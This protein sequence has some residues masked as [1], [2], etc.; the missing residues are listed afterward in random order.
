[1]TSEDR[2][3]YKLGFLGRTYQVD[4]LRHR[5][6]SAKAYSEWAVLRDQLND[7][8]HE[9]C[10]PLYF[11]EASCQSGVYVRKEIRNDG[12]DQVS[13][14]P[15]YAR[16]VQLR[17]RLEHDFRKE[18]ECPVSTRSLT[19]DAFHIY[20]QLAQ[21]ETIAAKG[22]AFAF[23]LT[24][25]FAKRLAILKDIRRAGFRVHYTIGCKVARFSDPS[26]PPYD[27]EVKGRL[28]VLSHEKKTKERKPK[29]LGD[30]TD[31][32]DDVPVAKPGKRGPCRRYLGTPKGDQT[33]K[34]PRVI[35][36]LHGLAVVTDPEMSDPL[37]K[38]QS[39]LGTSFVKRVTASNPL[40]MTTGHKGKT[41]AVAEGLLAYAVYMA[42]NYDQPCPIR[43]LKRSSIGGGAQRLTKLEKKNLHPRATRGELEA[44]QKAKEIVRVKLKRP[45]TGKQTWIYRHRRKIW[46]IAGLPVYDYPAKVI[47]RNGYSHNIRPQWGETIIHQDLIHSG[48][49]KSK[50]GL[51]E[52]RGMVTYIPCEYSRPLV[53]QEHAADRFRQHIGQNIRHPDG[54]LTD[55]ARSLIKSRIR[56]FDGHLTTAS[57][58]LIEE[59]VLMSDGTLSD[60]A[61]NHVIEGWRKPTGRLT[62]K[63]KRKGLSHRCWTADEIEEIKGKTL[64]ETHSG[65]CELELILHICR[66]RRVIEVSESPDCPI[67]K[68]HSYSGQLRPHADTILP[69]DPLSPTPG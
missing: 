37:G 35:P 17:Y 68:Y 8:F 66:F 23:T 14:S 21:E 6:Y 65:I 63:G 9:A 34:I 40:R 20:L 47:L 54:T 1:V 48:N 41:A 28:A 49:A 18:V 4:D 67:F 45:R 58:L 53:W 57:L 16:A 27:G 51:F 56:K 64:Y 69:A 7:R 36:H 52:N 62:D 26:F 55:K 39:I 29:S 2:Y 44:Y 38:L 19:Q 24:G 42:K 59:G 32:P 11:W 31:I 50:N 13:T 12:S 30:L 5:D 22:M 43:N 10:A 15:E 25:D 46:A 33:I 61:R 60:K 3:F